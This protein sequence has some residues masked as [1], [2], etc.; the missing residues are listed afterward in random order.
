MSIEPLDEP[1]A[2]H[3][4]G[5]SQV[6]EI[7]AEPP[8]RVSLSAPRPLLVAAVLERVEAANAAAE[9]ARARRRRG[10]GGQ[11]C[12]F[13]S[14]KQ[15]SPTAAETACGATFNRWLGSRSTA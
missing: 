3:A 7:D 14:W 13:F 10:L 1:D 12:P 2:G 11:L 9:Q 8:L 5:N 4:G 15:R 6:A